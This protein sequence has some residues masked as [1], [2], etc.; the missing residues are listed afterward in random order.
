M[1]GGAARA[2][3]ITVSSGGTLRVYGDYSSATNVTSMTGADVHTY[4]SATITYK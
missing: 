1:S 4:D 3:D 2:D